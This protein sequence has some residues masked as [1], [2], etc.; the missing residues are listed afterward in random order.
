MDF[1]CLMK[2]NNYQMN[3]GL[4]W[5]FSSSGLIWFVFRYTKSQSLPHLLPSPSYSDILD[6]STKHFAQQITAMDN[7][8]RPKET[9]RSQKGK[10]ILM[11]AGAVQASDPPPMP[12]LGLVE[13]V[14]RK[15]CCHSCRN[16]RTGT[17]KKYLVKCFL[18]LHV[19][20]DT[21]LLSSTR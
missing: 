18:L 12:R 8:S 13:Q 3:I 6:I 5:L 11:L 4:I 20:L 1:V 19:F 17:A 21:S 15:R 7:V 9:C 16:H 2:M 14:K 10:N